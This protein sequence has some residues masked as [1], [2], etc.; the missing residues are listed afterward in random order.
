M[1]TTAEVEAPED[2]TSARQI[3]L[4]LELDLSVIEGVFVNGTVYDLG[5]S[6]MPGDRIA[7]VPQGTPGPHRVYLGLYSAGRADAGYAEESEKA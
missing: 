4:D 7:F 2:G 3:A 1:P 5:H 6:V